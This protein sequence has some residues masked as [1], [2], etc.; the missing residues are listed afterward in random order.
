MFFSSTAW[1]VMRTARFLT[2]WS[3]YRAEIP[4]NVLPGWVWGAW[5]SLGFSMVLLAMSFLAIHWAGVWYTLASVKNFTEKSKFEKRSAA[6]K[7]MILGCWCFTTLVYVVSYIVATSRVF[8]PA[9]NDF[10]LQVVSPLMLVFFE[11]TIGGLIVNT[12]TKISGVMA[13]LAQQ[14]SG[15]GMGSSYDPAHLNKYVRR[16]AYFVIA[17]GA[18]AGFG[19]MTYLLSSNRF[20]L[21]AAI[22][23]SQFGGAAAV[24]ATY[25]MKASRRRELRIAAMKRELGPQRSLGSFGTAGKKPGSRGKLPTTKPLGPGGPGGVATAV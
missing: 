2:L 13:E 9:F 12:G 1:A 3:L 15:T 23:G 6:S 22:M 10:L 25:K 20:L 16:V 18:V 21:T 24:S 17:G 4:A 14:N 5:D 7:W 11:F 19:V 8:E